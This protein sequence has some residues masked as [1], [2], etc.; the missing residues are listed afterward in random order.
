MTEAMR[1]EQQWIQG[2]SRLVEY[3]K[4][5]GTSSVPQ[6]YR[7]KDG[8]TL[9]AWVAAQRYKQKRGR[10]NSKQI[11]LLNKLN[12]LWNWRETTWDNGI[13]HLKQYYEAYHNALVPESYRSKDGY[14]LGAWVQRQRKRYGKDSG[15]QKAL[16]EEQIKCLNQ[17]DFV[18]VC[19]HGG[20]WT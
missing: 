8:T 10:L 1:W 11:E 16:T 6:S 2:Y 18:W 14:Y 3:Y 5:H 19:E 15:R 7:C 4:E 17:Y 20:W 12:F 13:A 9:G